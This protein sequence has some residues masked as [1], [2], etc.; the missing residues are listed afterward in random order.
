M[1]CTSKH[2]KPFYTTAEL[3]DMSG[4]SPRQVRRMLA[5]H[6]VQR[7]DGRIPL[8]ELRDK[9][10]I[11]WESLTVSEAVLLDLDDRE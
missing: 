7:L 3:A 9:L 4:L 10:A 6:G 5:K 8:S 1:R 11:F 2:V